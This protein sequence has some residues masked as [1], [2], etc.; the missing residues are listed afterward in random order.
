MRCFTRGPSECLLQDQIVLGKPA[1]TGLQGLPRHRQE[2]S[3]SRRAAEPQSRMEKKQNA[4]LLG[5]RISLAQR[6]N[7]ADLSISYRP[8]FL[9]LS[10]GSAAWMIRRRVLIFL[11]GLGWISDVGG[12]ISSCENVWGLAG[13]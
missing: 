13:S 12:F 6:T 10:I 9:I 7:G 4:D 2:E 8:C 3:Q 5:P 11:I 1:R